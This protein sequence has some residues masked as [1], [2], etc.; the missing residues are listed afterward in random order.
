LITSRARPAAAAIIAFVNRRH[1]L[2]ALAAPLVAQS[3]PDDRTARR[4]GQPGARLLMVHADDAGMCHSVNVATAEALLGGGVQSASIMVPCPWF[5]EFAETARTHPELDLGLHLTLTSEWRHYRWGPVA[6]REKVRG[7]LDKEGFLFRDVP[8]VATSA[9]LDEVALELRAQIDKARQFGVRF[10][11]VDTHMGTL[12]AR[13]DYFEV[14]T[15]VAREAK[16]PCMIPRPTAVARA[17][18]KG[19][20]ITPEM[21]EKKEADGFVLLDRLVTRVPGRSVADRAES[22]RKFLREL[23]PGVTKLI[24][25]LAKDDPEIRAVT[26]AWEARWAD[27]S[28]FTSAESKRL[29]AE[30]G[31]KPVTY[32]ELGRLSA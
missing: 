4:L 21:L 23:Q 26:N 30:L 24:V 6:P 12:Y 5:S 29:L 1:F 9:D 20:P 22:Y 2:G 3:S 31:I 18:L 15:A 28:F 7:L 16:V 14:Y 13:P 19:Y 32:R 11:H 27:Y 10:T 25:H 8:S 17:E